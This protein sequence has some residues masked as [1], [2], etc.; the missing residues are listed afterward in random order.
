MP[1]PI[2][3]ED[4]FPYWA[5][6]LDRIHIFWCLPHDTSFPIKQVSHVYETERWPKK[7]SW[8][9]FH[10][11]FFDTYKPYQ[12]SMSHKTSFPLVPTFSP[13]SKRPGK[14]EDP[15]SRGD[16]SLKWNVLIS[17]PHMCLC[18]RPGFTDLVLKTQSH[19]RDKILTTR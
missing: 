17:S 4:L 19:C 11:D 10:M 12:L 7:I 14:T 6:I 15:K 13:F 1:L 5:L 3:N 16:R 2:W 8:S 9:L 18:I